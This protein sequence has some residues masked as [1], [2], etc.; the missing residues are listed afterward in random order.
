MHT[1]M[2]HGHVHTPILVRDAS[3]VLESSLIA[4]Q[5]NGVR[6][7]LLDPVLQHAAQACFSHTQEF[8]S[9]HVKIVR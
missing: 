8:R 3:L 7:W 4:G 1:S 9:G 2:K 6:A 5:D